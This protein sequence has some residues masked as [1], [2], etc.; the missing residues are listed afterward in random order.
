MGGAIGFQSGNDWRYPGIGSIAVFGVSNPSSRVGHCRYRDQ[1]A[2]RQ[3]NTKK[4]GGTVSSDAGVHE[5][6]KT[7]VVAL[8]DPT[9][10]NAIDQVQFITGLEVE[11]VI[12]S[13][14]SILQAIHKYYLGADLRS[15]NKKE[16]VVEETANRFEADDMQRHGG[17]PAQE[18]PDL[19]IFGQQSDDDGKPLERP[20]T[21]PVEDIPID[22]DVGRPLF[23]FEKEEMPALEPAAP[24]GTAAVPDAAELEKFSEQ[25]KLIGL[26]HVLLKKRLVTE[27]EIAQELTR[28]WAL[29]KLK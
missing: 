20:R 13:Y 26:Y 19:I 8:A 7:L 6:Q 10:L 14:S 29:G 3:E 17:R 23:D 12:T 18:D 24:T 22:E 16:I 27:G 15:S 21:A 4:S 9:D 28:L 2:N 5:G 11:P 1:S 25:Q